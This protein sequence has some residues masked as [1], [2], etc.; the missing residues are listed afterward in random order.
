M[1]KPIAENQTG[2]GNQEQTFET[3]GL[4]IGIPQITASVSDEIQ[5]WWVVQRKEENDLRVTMRSKWRGLGNK[6]K[7][8]IPQEDL[9]GISCLR[10][11]S[12]R[13]EI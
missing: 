13:A 9:S 7:P 3:Y 8:L 1:C 5:N 2:S 10:G 12:L 11:E 6:T 4:V